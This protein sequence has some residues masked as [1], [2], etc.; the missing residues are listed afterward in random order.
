M[1][2][3]GTDISQCVLEYISGGTLKS[4]IMDMSIELPWKLRV[5]LVKDVACGMV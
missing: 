5:K 3:V 1:Y 2:F 4:R